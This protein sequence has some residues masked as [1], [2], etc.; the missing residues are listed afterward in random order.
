M[1]KKTM[2]SFHLMVKDCTYHDLIVDA[3]DIDAATDLVREWWVN[4]ELGT[5]DFGS[6]VLLDQNEDELEEF[7]C[8]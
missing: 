6:V 5:G 8:W 7:T 3:P 1:A 4:G 2:R